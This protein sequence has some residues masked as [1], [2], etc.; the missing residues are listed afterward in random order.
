MS[1]PN[2]P[3][4]E[5][6]CPWNYFY[7]Y[8]VSVRDPARNYIYKNIDSCKIDFGIYPDVCKIHRN[9]HF[10][11]LVAGHAKI[12]LLLEERQK[13]APGATAPVLLLYPTYI[14]YSMSLQGIGPEKYVELWCEVIAA[15]L[16]WHPEGIVV[17]RPNVEGRVHPLVERISAKFAH[18]GR[19]FIDKED[20][21]KFWMAR[22]D[23]FVTDYSE[24]YANFCLS[25]KRPVIR[26]VYTKE[27]EEP[28]RDEWGWTVSR[29]GQVIPLLIQVDMEEDLWVESLRKIQEREMPTLGR[30]FARMASMI[31][32]I[33]HNDDDPAWFRVDKG[34]TPCRTTGDLL[35]LVAKGVKYEPFTLYLMRIWLN[36]LLSSTQAQETPKIWLGLL[37]RALLPRLDTASPLDRDNPLYIA[38]YI[39]EGLTVTLNRMPVQQ[40]V[41]LLRH[42][43]HKDASLTATALLITA[44]S[45]YLRGP[46]KKR[47]LFFL[48]M[49][50][51]RYDRSVLQTVNDLAE[52]MPQHFSGPVLDRLNH[53]LPR[54]MKI[55]LP[56]RR[57]ASVALGLKKPL[58]K[59]YWRAHR[60]L[61]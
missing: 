18:D 3:T 60:A 36:D 32:R 6:P 46:E 44:T 24:A 38:K 5:S 40:T 7:D 23:Y 35:R 54:V 4:L 41:G 21:N 56:M 28:I 25:A 59:K 45:H 2:H 52:K 37:K 16:A 31:L 17:F 42:C 12:D 20:N 29:A 58:A 9:P 49:E 26:M 43:M 47:A 61:C 8:V 27:E 50:W 51:A 14:N 39:N 30:N 57:L 15:Y 55:P 22:A 19:L 33:F 11:Q 53:V 48:L 1:I 10:T 34:H 13:K